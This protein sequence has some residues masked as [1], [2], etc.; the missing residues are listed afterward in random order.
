MNVF[1]AESVLFEDGSKVEK[2]SV[3]ELSEDVIASELKGLGGG[4][5]A[6]DVVGPDM[7][8]SA[9]TPLAPKEEEEGT[10]AEVAA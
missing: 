10:I 6:S 5:P 9:V 1:E 4:D 7:V 2:P 3:E 8:G